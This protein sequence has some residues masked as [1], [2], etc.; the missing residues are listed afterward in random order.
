MSR[1]AS[2]DGVLQSD[3]TIWVLDHG[4]PSLPQS[5]AIGTVVPVARW[6][7]PEVGA[8]LHVRFFEDEIDGEELDSDVEVAFR[9][10]GRW[11][12]FGG[13]GGTGW[14]D[15]P[16][17]RPE[18]QERLAEDWSRYTCS[19]PASAACAIYGVAG[20]AAT[21]VEVSDTTGTHVM[22]IESPLGAFVAASGDLETGTVRVLD[23]DGSPLLTETFAVPETSAHNRD[24]YLT[25]FI[26]LDPP[27]A[28]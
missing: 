5:P 23:A 14:F 2:F 21:T 18:M 7:G 15:P 13:S 16:F 19:S 24:G 8:V 10:E 28:P 25:D 26:E 17:I 22:P 12:V 1:P 3:W 4:L 27:D 6:V 11:E 9:H 20:T